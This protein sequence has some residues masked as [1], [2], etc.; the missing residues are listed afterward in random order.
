MMDGV[1]D[2]LTELRGEGKFKAYK[3][4]DF[5]KE[6]LKGEFFEI[7]TPKELFTKRVHHTLEGPQIEQI[8]IPHAI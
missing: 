3:N 7:E 5:M 4:Y 2:L 6:I 1:V 8:E